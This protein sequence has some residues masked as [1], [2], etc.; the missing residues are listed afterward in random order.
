M[1]QIASISFWAKTKASFKTDSE[2]S[3]AQHSIIFI[4]HFLPA[5]NKFRL[6]KANSSLLG[7]TKNS[8][9]LYQICTAPTGQSNGIPA[10]ITEIEEPT[11]VITSNSIL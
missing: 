7:F 5:T 6:H 2:T 3:F 10:T 4:L 11:I 9:S 8:Q 1:S